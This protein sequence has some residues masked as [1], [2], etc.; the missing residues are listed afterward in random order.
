MNLSPTP[1]A[2]TSGNGGGWSANAHLD[3]TTNNNVH[4]EEEE[5]E[6][7]E[8]SITRAAM[9]PIVAATGPKNSR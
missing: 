3:T 5:E 1:L 4:Q 2:R 9:T 7:E 6:E 8:C